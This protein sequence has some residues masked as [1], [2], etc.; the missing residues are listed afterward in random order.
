MA[1]NSTICAGIDIGKRRLDVA[2]HGSRAQFETD[3]TLA[4]HQKLVAWLKRRQ[5]ERIGLEATGGYET[6]VVRALRHAGLVVAVLQPLQV[7]AFAQ[8]RLKLAKSDKI[9][10]VIIADC[11]ASVEEIRDAPDPRFEAFAATQTLI[12]QLNDDVVICKTRL[13]TTRDETSRAFWKREITTRQAQARSVRKTLRA[14]MRA[15]PDLAAKLDLIVSIQ[16][17]AE[18]TAMAILI[19][20][21]EIG[22]LSRE[23]VAALA[24]LAPYDDDSGRRTG[25]RYIKGGRTRLRGC[26]YAAAFAAS[27]HWNPQLKTFY[28]R[29]RARG[30]THKLA[31]VACAR[32]LLIFANTIVARGT[33]WQPSNVKSNGCS[34][35]RDS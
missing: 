28:K 2:L 24:G 20:M 5:V 35:R 6:E 26:L 21:P 33:P 30:K 12:D 16:G 34:G 11:V 1:N 3:N 29:L 19:R 14:A 27:F 31:L 18:K 25:Q 32:K 15:Y 13:E 22:S 8:F 4:G 10:A 17:I 7:R 9:D 23:Q